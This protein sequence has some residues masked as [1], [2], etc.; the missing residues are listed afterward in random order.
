MHSEAIAR[1]HELV[2][3]VLEMLIVVVPQTTF[4]GLITLRWASLKKRK[5][6]CDDFAEEPPS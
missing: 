5:N 2:E 4:A 1:P 6:V 3:P